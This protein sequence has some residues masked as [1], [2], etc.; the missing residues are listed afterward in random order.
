[1]TMNAKLNSET[2]GVAVRCI[3]LVDAEAREKE[4]WDAFL[5][6]EKECGEKIDAL[7]REMQEASEAWGKAYHELSRLRSSEASTVGHHLQPESEAKGC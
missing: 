1:M 2:N 6:I 7:R 3:G 4:L 5:R